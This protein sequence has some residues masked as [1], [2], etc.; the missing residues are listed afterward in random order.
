L[1]ELKP[2][3][4]F[5]INPKIRWSGIATFSGQVVFCQMRPGVMSITP[6]DD[7]KL[8]LE[9]RAHY[10]TQTSQQVTRWAGPVE[11]VAVSYEKFV[12]LIMFVKDG[13]AVV[14]LE[15]DVPPLA[16]AEITKAVQ[17][18]H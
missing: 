6:Q 15:K 4:V 2:E 11:Y 7:D 18:L 10:I 1:F 8:F 9:L 13:Y 14:T 17:A 16:F 12:E 3:D 5:E